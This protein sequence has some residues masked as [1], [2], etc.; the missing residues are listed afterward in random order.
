VLEGEE[1][2]LNGSKA[3]ITN[4][5]EA[6]AAIVFATT[7]KSLKHKGRVMRVSVIFGLSCR[8]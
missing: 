3:W 5:H 2:V 7:D 4:A 8:L 1:Y 6:S